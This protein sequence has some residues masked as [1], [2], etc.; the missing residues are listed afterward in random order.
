[1]DYFPYPS[2]RPYQDRMLDAVYD[3]VGKGGH[4]ILMIDAPTGCGKTS[5]LSAA[6]A[7]APGKIVVALRTISQIEI[8]LDEISRIWSNTRHRP[9]VS[10]LIGKQKVC[11]LV[12]EFKGESVYFACSRLREGSKIYM[13][14]KLK[15]SHD[16]LYDPS[17]DYIPVEQPGERT[18]CPHYLKSREALELNGE[19]VF[20][21][22]TRTVEAVERLRS[23]VTPTEKLAGICKGACPYEVMSLYAKSSQIII[24]NYHH[25][26]SPDFQDAIMQWLELEPDKLTL[27][28][29]EAHNL[30]DAV[31]AMNSRALTLRMIA[32]AEK[33]V[34]KYE[35]V[36]SQV[37]LDEGSASKRRAA[38][39]AIG[40]IMP[41]LTRFIESRG[42]RMKE[43]EALMDSDIFREFLY[44]DIEDIDGTLSSMSEISLEIAEKK[45][46]EGDHENAQGVL[47]PS[48]AQVVLFLREIE[49]AEKD[50][51]L[52]RKVVVSG[53]KDRRWTRLEVTRI[54]PAPVIR[55]IVDNVSSTV[56]LS[57]TFSPMDAYEL[58]YFGEENRARQLSLPNPFPK[59]N[60]LLLASEQATTQLEARDDAEN[61]HEIA[62]HIEVLIEEV[63]GNVAIF[64]TSYSMMNGFIDVCSRSAKNAGKQIFVEPRSADEVPAVLDGF[65]RQGKRKGGVLLG[66]SGGKLAEGIDYKGEA[67]NGV[68]VVGLPLSAFDEIQ[69]E[70]I[71]YYT[72]KYGKEKGTLIAY[73]LPAINRGLQA[74]GRVI[75]AETERGVILFCDRRFGSGGS[76]GVRNYLPEWVQSEITGTSAAKSRDI[77]G[78]KRIN[79]NM[80]LSKG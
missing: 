72:R 44:H 18:V 75:R 4:G 36:L 79:W 69:R 68:A 35:N 8:Y 41:R 45:L 52:Q 28:V 20:R 31:R 13:K 66:V 59:E 25:I 21:R 56:M 11:P 48:L 51:S 39:S 77:I 43:G 74:A 32:L 3:T 61:R 30:G 29:D 24:L 54:D 38:L 12:D 1:M 50:E 7:A 2:L 80:P 71:G 42:K 22:S 47:Q 76:G 46:A 63:P 26:F 57:G 6:L 70:I 23:E 5:C 40:V 49:D 16:R 9:E 17:K 33:E 34:E 67:L 15:K 64:F 58:Y 65:F 60:R 10:Y 37:R 78:M 73:T 55:R 19:V 14:E 62:G 53:T 27:I